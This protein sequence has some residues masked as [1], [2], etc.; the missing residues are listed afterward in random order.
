MIRTKKIK[1]KKS[2]INQSLKV[3][4]NEKINFDF[5]IPF[6]FFNF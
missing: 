5:T 3:E 1:T 2:E 6:Y 4:I